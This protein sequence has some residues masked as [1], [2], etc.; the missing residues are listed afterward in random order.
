M[1]LHLN[2]YFCIRYSPT[3]FTERNFWLISI[4]IIILS[5][6]NLNLLVPPFGVK[7]R[8][9]FCRPRCCSSFFSLNKLVR[10]AKIK[11]VNDVMTMMIKIES[12]L[13]DNCILYMYIFIFPLALVLFLCYLTSLTNSRFFTTDSICSM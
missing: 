12:I 1:F 3:Y 2:E 5:K 6:L 13:W 9:R 8:N 10:A 7:T 4:H 11:F